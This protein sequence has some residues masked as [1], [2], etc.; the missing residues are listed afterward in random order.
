M[1]I[2]VGAEGQQQSHH[3]RADADQA[4]L[5][6]VALDGT[7]MGPQDGSAHAAA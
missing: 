7:R 2:N 6:D 5:P 1:R 3:E 4:R